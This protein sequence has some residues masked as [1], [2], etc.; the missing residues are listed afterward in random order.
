[1]T[2]EQKVPG[3]VGIVLRT[4]DPQIV[5][6]DGDRFRSVARRFQ[7]LQAYASEFE[8]FAVAKRSKRI[9]RFSRGAQ[10]DSCA[11]SIAQLQMPGD[12]IGVEMRQKYVLDLEPV[13]GGKRNVLVRVP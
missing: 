4:A 9:R 6:D 11:R 13:L 2:Q 1:H 3:E 10:V 5:N 7:H 8:R 12:K